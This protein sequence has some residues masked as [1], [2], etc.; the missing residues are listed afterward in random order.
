MSPST[1]HDDTSNAAQAPPTTGHEKAMSAPDIVV[2]PPD[3][4]RGADVNER[5]LKMPMG[6]KGLMEHMEASQ[7][8]VDENGAT[9]RRDRELSF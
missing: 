1:N 9:A 8:Q 2:D 3:Q 7:K 5:V 6:L 4:E